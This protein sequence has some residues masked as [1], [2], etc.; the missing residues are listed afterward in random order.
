[1]RI[2]VLQVSMVKMYG[3]QHFYNKSWGLLYS[4]FSKLKN[5]LYQDSKNNFYLFQI[6]S[7]LPEIRS[8]ILEEFREQRVRWLL[9]SIQEFNSMPVN[10]YQNKSPNLP[11]HL[12]N[13]KV[14]IV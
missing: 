1:M 9:D 2:L 12:H 7:S 3:F 14:Q 13:F 10:E 11:Q 6:E 4:K 8:M 5:T